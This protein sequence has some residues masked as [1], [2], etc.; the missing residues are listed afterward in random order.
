MSNTSYDFDKLSLEISHNGDT[1]L[2]V[3]NEHAIETNV[4]RV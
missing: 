2:I 1:H 4:K 3:M